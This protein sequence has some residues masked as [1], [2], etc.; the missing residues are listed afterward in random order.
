MVDQIPEN[1][2]LK[3]GDELV[4]SGKG[5]L[6]PAGI[7]I[8]VIVSVDNSSELSRYATLK[9]YSDVTSINDVFIL[10]PEVTADAEVTPS[11]SPTPA[12]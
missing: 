8:G 4:T 3:V 10:V 5:G 9:P 12:A 6:F 1:V 7:P 11:P 2:E